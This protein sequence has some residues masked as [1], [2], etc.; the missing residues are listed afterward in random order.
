M[1][2]LF[3]RRSLTAVGIYS[4]VALGYLATVLASRE[5][6][7][8]RAFGDYATV[9][10]TTG[11]LQSFFDLT[12]EEALVKYGFR[13]VTREDWGRLRALFRS[14]L[15]VKLAGSLLGAGGLLVFAALAP[16]RLTV[17]I[18]LA[19][20]IPLG[21]SLEGLAGSAL[22]LR[23][24]YDVRAAFLTWSMA[25]RLAG[26][27]VGAH[28]GLSEAVAG[29]LAGQLLAAA[30]V[31]LAGRLALRRFPR[32]TQ[33]PLGEERREIVSFVLQ[34]SAATGVLSLRGG[35]GPLLLG[36]VTG[37]TQVGLFKVA[38]APQ[39]G[40]QALSAP[41]RMVLL[42][43]QTRDWEG[44]RQSVV[45]R[46]VRRYSLV[47]FLLSIVAVPPL[48]VFVPDLIRLVNGARYVGASGAARIF[49]LVA[50][51]QLIVGWTKS[52]PVSIGR[53]GLRIWTHGVETLVVLPLIVV[54][55][56]FWGATGAAGA[57]LA[58]MCVFAAMWAVIF[59]RIRPEDVG[60]PAPLGEA[61]AD[62]EI[63]AGALAR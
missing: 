36:A 47:A 23:G 40:F 25:L 15:W 38:Q 13:Y 31:G 53:P 45:L 63:E 39:S 18:L 24:R 30:S 21:Q 20:G 57:M 14:A 41:A 48:Y 1:P 43:E 29:V 50:A 46:G 4:S 8:T 16:S 3:V 7:S 12:V 33:R 9:I 35:L 17:P 6:H 62:E 37:T 2:R 5:L 22:Y 10:F 32:G 58:G 49:V 44:G 27:G 34:S 54:L 42:T 56:N 11:F 61:L 19:A 59:L 51:V 52:F 55:G 60:R 28:F 26:V